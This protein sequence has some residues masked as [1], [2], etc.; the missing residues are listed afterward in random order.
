MLQDNGK[1]EHGPGGDF[2]K[3]RLFWE[4]NIFCHFCADKKSNTEL[5]TCTLYWRERTKTD[6]K[7]MLV[8]CLL[9]K[10]GYLEICNHLQHALS[11]LGHWREIQPHFLSWR[12]PPVCLPVSM[13]AQVKVKSIDGAL[14]ISHHAVIQNT[15]QEQQK[16][17]SPKGPSPPKPLTSPLLMICNVLLL[18]LEYKCILGVPWRIAC[19]YDEKNGSPPQH[20]Y[21]PRNT[22]AT[23]K[24]RG[25]CYWSE[26]VKINM[27]FV[28]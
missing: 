24:S 9:N 11:L 8:C 18:E 4:R 1:I 14:T 16:T 22:W 21:S 23:S 28:S 6:S 19:T 20:M 2:F 10:K 12:S 15:L 3:N 26:K 17:N 13:T 25:T 7:L 27:N 5:R